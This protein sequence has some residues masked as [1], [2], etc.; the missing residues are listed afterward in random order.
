MWVG[1]LFTALM[2]LLPRGT[3]DNP[4]TLPEVI[5]QRDNPGTLPTIVWDDPDIVVGW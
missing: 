4:G 5:I 3:G 2:A 1:I